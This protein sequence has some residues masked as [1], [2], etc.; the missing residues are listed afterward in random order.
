MQVGHRLLLALAIGLGLVLGS[1]V[2]GWHGAT[3]ADEKDKKDPPTTAKEKEP[4]KEELGE[5]LW[6]VDLEAAKM[7]AAKEGKDI[8][9]EFTGSDWCP[10]CKALKRK[11]FDTE[12][13]QTEAPKHFVLVKLDNPRDKSKQTDKEI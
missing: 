5:K 7:V 11:V 1:H 4:A 3:R 12:A 6:M 8:L 2:L 13:F 10:P 9:M